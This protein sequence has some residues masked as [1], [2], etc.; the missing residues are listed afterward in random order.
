[1]GTTGAV[2]RK[3]PHTASNL[4]L[5]ELIAMLFFAAALALHLFGRR[6]ATL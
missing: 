1:V 6:R 2:R 3:L 5:I 4:P